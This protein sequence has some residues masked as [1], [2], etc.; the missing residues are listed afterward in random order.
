MYNL[1]LYIFYKLKFLYSKFNLI[2]LYV[3]NI[4]LCYNLY[5]LEYLKGLK[6]QNYNFKTYAELFIYI[7]KNHSNK[8]FLNY[9]ENGQYKHLSVQDFEHRVKYLCYA[10][11]EL[12]INQN[13]NVAIYTIPCPNWL[14][15]DFALQL[16]GANSVPIFANIS[17]KN[18]NYE[19]SD[20]NIKY[21]F[22]NIDLP[23]DELDK[24]LT[25]ISTSVTKNN[26]ISL[27]SLYEKGKELFQNKIYDFDEL[28][29]S[30]KEEDT[31]SIIYTSG[32]TGIPKGVELT[33]KNI[34]SQLHCINEDFDV[35]SNDRAL[36][37]LPLAH[38]FERAVMS[39]YLSRGT[40]IYFVDDLLNIALLMKEVKPTIMTVVPRLLEKIFN[41]MKTK[42]SEK[43]GI[44]RF[45]AYA[46]FK[47]ALEK[48][49]DFSLLDTLYDKLVYSKLRESFGGELEILVTG[50]ASLNKEIYQFFVNIGLNLYQGYGL[51]EFSPVICANT[52]KHTKVGTSG[53]PFR[54]VEVKLATDNEL[55]ARGSS[56]M[57][58]YKNQPELTAQAIDKEGWLHTG[59]LAGIDDEGYITIH[60]RKKE[61]FKTSN[62][63]YVSVIPIE[64]E[65]TKSRFIDYTAVIAN[66]RKY[67][68]AL[69]FT[70]MQT[71]E[72]YKQKY[73]LDDSFTIEDFYNKKEVRNKLQRDIDSINNNLNKWEQIV[74][75]EI[76][77]QTLSIE[78]GELTPSMKI[79]RAVI[80]KKY[81]N[82]IN[83]MY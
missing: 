35:D 66:N 2:F 19:I 6:M 73:Q 68:T 30:V 80:E 59:D 78:N 40:S 75:Y 17:S 69:I 47:R 7:T 33:H 54:G 74:K 41:K 21:I 16:I 49:D 27:T 5:V 34:I 53:L 15:F 28:I 79:C 55:L 58:G 77:T 14:I 82:K 44:S 38:I 62:G 13:D 67:V 70:D 26:A 83:A 23:L 45:I 31:F 10:L 60:S 64:Q 20:S 25:I 72:L 1:K 29:Q 9:R 37:L 57:K 4:H 63:E 12:G 22:T 50:G 3:I 52:P 71:Y 8:T 43:K 61:L 39:F 81:E 51:T 32:S 76:I 42:I 18:L 56:V 48:R 24:D 11:K 36:S 65:L 46:A